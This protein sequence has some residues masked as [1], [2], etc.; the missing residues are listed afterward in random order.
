MRYFTPCLPHP[1]APMTTY[2]PF[3]LYTSG[4]VSYNGIMTL[5]IDVRK[6]SLEES[7]VLYAILERFVKNVLNATDGAD[8]AVIDSIVS[9]LRALFPFVDRWLDANLNLTR[10]EE[11][12]FW[13]GMN[14]R[15]NEATYLFTWNVRSLKTTM[16]PNF[17]HEGLDGAVYDMIELMRYLD[18]EFLKDHSY[19]GLIN[20]RN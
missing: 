17:Y 3:A 6:F 1:Y 11:Q 4:L 13:K 20:Q 8:N 9:D 16:E 14:V 10:E 19:Q 7:K 15:K 18:E 12:E 5:E 2:H